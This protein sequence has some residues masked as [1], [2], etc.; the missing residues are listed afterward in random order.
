MSAR[1]LV[2]GGGGK[3][4]RRLRELDPAVGAPTRAEMDVTSPESIDRYCSAWDP[5]VIIHAA[6]VTNR[7]AEEVDEEYIRTNIIGTANV[8]LWA[9]PR[10]V[11]LVY[12]SSDY[13][14]PSERGGYTEESVLLPVN[15]Y[16]AS[17]LG[18]EM[19]VLLCPN[20]LIVRTSFYDTLAFD[21]ACTDQFTSRLPIDELARAVLMLARRDDVRG[22]LNVGTAAPRSVHDIVRAEFRPGVAAVRRADIRL[23]YIL[24]PDSSMDTSKYQ[25]LATADATDSRPVARCRVCN[26]DRLFPYLDLGRTP[27]ANS[28]LRPEERDAPEFTEELAI[29]LCPDCGLSQL[30]RVV[31]PDRMFKNYLYVSSTTQT[32]RDHCEEL[33]DSTM[34]VTG[35]AAGDLALDVASNDGCLLTKFR[36]RGMNVVG[37]DP[38]ENLAAEANAA[39]IR[40]ICA[41]WSVPVAKD[42]QARFGSPT[43]ITATNV[44]A[45]V[46]DVHGF[47][48]AVD[49]CMAPRGI[50]VIEAPYLVDFIERNEFD[51]A[52][53][54]HLSYLAIHPLRTLMAAHGMTVF[55][56]EYFKDL[57]GGTVRVSSCRTGVYAPTPAVERFL[58]GE[59][60]FGLFDRARYTA[61]A[62]Q[63]MANKRDLRALV[64][65]L[66]AE[67]KTIWAYGA[68]A[69]GNTLMNF[70]EL[71]DREIPVVIDDNPKKWGYLAPGSRMR[72]TGIEELGKH[73][74][75]YLLLLAWNFQAEIMRRCRAAKYAGDFITPVPAPAVVKNNP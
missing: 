22:V 40:T 59:R 39:G 64:A 35:A 62:E 19:A 63:V 71:T 73:R 65:K 27:L 46:D 32:F 10:G 25:H 16:A 49:A 15:R 75:D 30:T 34:R 47:V 8:A 9:R 43:I 69:K 28:Y 6:A 20:S 12:I 57:H 2:T 23:S 5:T 31:H 68:S 61:F 54:E 18:G 33:A 70:F 26:S 11:R 41:Y 50:F 67:G 36:D 48:N 55:D 1:I 58:A 17:K 72:I 44:F 7:H 66:R 13:V 37:V 38:A 14:Y 21:R 56:V 3:L 52:Y 29:Q 60:T 74:V 53:H 24:P 4:A 51:T 42:L 45:H